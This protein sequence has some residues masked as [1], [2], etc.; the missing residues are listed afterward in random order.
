MANFS[1]MEASY[2]NPKKKERKKQ[3]NPHLFVLMVVVSCIENSNEFFL[4]ST[5]PPHIIDMH[6]TSFSKT[7]YKHCLG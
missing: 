7:V 3:R 2:I 4:H 6:E 5:P 1:G